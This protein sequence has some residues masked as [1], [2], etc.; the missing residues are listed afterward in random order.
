MD[1]ADLFV[2]LVGR[3]LRFKITALL[4]KHGSLK[5]KQI[6][7]LL[8]RK[9]K[10]QSIYD[11]LA[12]LRRNNLVVRSQCAVVSL[13]TEEAFVKSVVKFINA[14]DDEAWRVLEEALLGS[15]GRA[16][17]LI[18][19]A[20]GPATKTRLTNITGQNVKYTEWLLE[21][22][23]KHNLVIAAGVDHIIYEL[24]HNHPLITALLSFFKEIGIDGGGRNGNNDYIEPA[25]R[26]V[27]YIIDNWDKYVVNPYNKGTIKLTGKVIAN[28]AEKLRIKV[29]HNGWLTTYVIEEF[30][31]RG[32][33]VQVVKNVRHRAVVEK[34]KIYVSKN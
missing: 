2:G 22:L 12:W 16:K 18:T 3:P 19:L 15:R 13:N 24:N 20:R 6:A 11:T 10:R 30:K 9:Y 17:I 26:I 21:P 5:P 8:G 32:F 23:L 4:A 25:K 31:R 28:I 7:I 1:N 29:K 33:K 34:I 27:D 14:L